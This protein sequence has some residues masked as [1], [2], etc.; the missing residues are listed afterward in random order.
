MI[1]LSMRDLVPRVFYSMI[2]DTSV[3]CCTVLRSREVWGSLDNLNEQ[4]RRRQKLLDAEEMRQQSMLVPSP[5]CM[6]VFICLSAIGNQTSN[7]TLGD[8]KEDNV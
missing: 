8:S 5:L 2:P 3:L 1:V 7:I 4:Y 6:C